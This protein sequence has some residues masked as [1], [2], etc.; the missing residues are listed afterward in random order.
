MTKRFLFSTLFC[1]LGLNFLMAAT[2][3]V[4]NEPS[5]PAQF[6][7]IQDAVNA[8]SSGDT[9]LIS[10]SA[11]PYQSPSVGKKL[12]I[13]G[14][15]YFP[16]TTGHKTAILVGILTFS[17]GSGGSTI[18]GLNIQEQVDV[19]DGPVR[20]D[21]NSIQSI[22]FLA[23]GFDL[24]AEDNFIRGQIYPAS[25]TIPSGVFR[26]NF[27]IC[28]PT[29]STL[30]GL[31][32]NL[33]F[34]HN[35]FETTNAVEIAFLCNGLTIQN[36]IFLG[37]SNFG[38]FTNCAFDHN[39]VENPNA[40]DLPLPNSFGINNINGATPLFQKKNPGSHYSTWDLQLVPFTV[41][42]GKGT[43]LKDIGL[44]TSNHP[45]SST[46]EPFG[47]P[48]VRTLSLENNIVPAGANIKVRIVASKAKN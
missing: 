45:Y 34:D 25:N 43:D 31:Q 13:Y 36:N 7:V 44:V 21:H 9:I 23:G 22:R 14:P 39:L 11:F 24:I 47:L 17:T 15:G 38:S 20:L 46:G 40:V 19:A 41:G 6:Q 5:A 37:P 28:V 32:G 12:Y 27:F 1:A 2:I 29:G 26:H 4:S 10:P 3:T 18:S 30:T 35:I 16:A 48:V 8:A 42:T 33:L